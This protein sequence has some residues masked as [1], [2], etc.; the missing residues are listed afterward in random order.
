MGSQSGARPPCPPP[1][2]SKVVSTQLLITATRDPDKPHNG[3][4]GCGWTGGGGSLTSWCLKPL[5]INLQAFEMS[6]Y[7]ENLFGTN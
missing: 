5:L 2:A 1:K 7:A 6:D 3:C 4:G